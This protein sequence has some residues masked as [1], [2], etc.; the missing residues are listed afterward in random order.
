MFTNSAQDLA[1]SRR[2]AGGAGSAGQDRRSKAEREAEAEGL[3][4]SYG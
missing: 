3:L 2:P 1:A 4:S